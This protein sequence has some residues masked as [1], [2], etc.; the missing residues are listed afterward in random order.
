MFMA[1]K[2]QVY[3]LAVSFFSWIFGI[4]GSMIFLF[5]VYFLG[6]GRGRGLLETC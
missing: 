3:N 4:L 5:F 6:E 2:G 1:I